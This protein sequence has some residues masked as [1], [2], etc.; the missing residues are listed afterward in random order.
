MT[1]TLRSYFEKKI[2]VGLKKLINDDQYTF[3]WKY[4]FPNGKSEDECLEIL[5]DLKKDNVDLCKLDALGKTLC[6]EMCVMGYLKVAVFLIEENNMD[7]NTQDKDR[8]WTCLFDAI[9]HN[10]LHVVKYLASKE[11]TDINLITEHGITPLKLA[12]EMGHFG[13]VKCLVQKGADVHFTKKHSITKYYVD[14]NENTIQSVRD[15]TDG[16]Y[17]TALEVAVEKNNLPIV[18]YLI[19]KNAALVPHNYVGAKHNPLYLA[20]K[21]LNYEMVEYLFK[22]ILKSE[23]TDTII[24]QMDS[25]VVDLCKLHYCYNK[26]IS[27]M[28][29]L[30]IGEKCSN[31]KRTTSSSSSSSSSSPPTTTNPKRRRK[32]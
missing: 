14:Q 21:K 4:I 30:L 13:I 32:K 19:N 2:N 10:H 16:D 3:T 11:D 27:F 26:V 18:K 5:T 29:K 24:H 23:T 12:V 1:K 22:N 9:K 7:P 15:T 6:H 8:K 25:V 28:N 31:K 17:Y 20:C